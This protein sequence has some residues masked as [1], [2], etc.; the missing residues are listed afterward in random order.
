[1]K[2][3]F[4]VDQAEAFRRGLDCP[5][6]IVSIEID[7]AT[8]PQETRNLLA[9]R[10]QGIDVLQLFY[11]D[12]EILKGH[13]FKELLQTAA[14]PQ[15]I[16][17]TAPTFEELVIAVREN[18]LTIESCRRTFRQAVQF[19]LLS[20]P[21]QNHQDFWF[22][23]STVPDW[24]NE[25]DVWLSQGNRVVFE[26]FLHDIQHTLNEK[27]NA[28]HY[29]VMLLPIPGSTARGRFY[30]ERLFTGKFGV[31]NVTAHS[32]VVVYNEKSGR[33]VEASNLFQA[34]DIYLFN[35]T[36]HPGIN[37]NDLHILRWEE[38]RWVIVAPEPLIDLAK[39]RLRAA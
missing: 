35:G 26:T 29:R 27:L 14:E 8:L 32:R 5:K 11:V 9:N 31:T 2:L 30:C 4:E 38:E 34:L 3:R 7:P 10:M 37:I 21:P 1:M 24:L 18:E 19:Q 12:G 22:V 17:T 6:S 39:T 23:S 33:I 25:L 20:A 13:P 16:R 28:K 15:R 36:T